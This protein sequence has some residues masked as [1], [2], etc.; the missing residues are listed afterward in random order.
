MKKN[1]GS[2]EQTRYLEFKESQRNQG[3]LIKFF[4][5][6]FQIFSVVAT[7]LLKPWTAKNGICQIR[8]KIGSF[9][10]EKR[11]L[12]WRRITLFDALRN[13][14]LDFRLQLW[15]TQRGLIQRIFVDQLSSA[16]QHQ[17]TNNNHVNYNNNEHYETP[18]TSKQA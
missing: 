10:V 4:I 12:W 5:F 18:Q 3:S 9:E 11:K 2:W 1:W 15:Q 14:A 8:K 7:T 6:V 13:Y 16:H 17:I